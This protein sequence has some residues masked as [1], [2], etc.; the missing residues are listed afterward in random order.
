MPTEII[1]NK[2]IAE[3]KEVIK[4]LPVE[5]KLEILTL[6][7]EDL[8]ALRFKALLARFRSSARQYPLTLE[9]ITKEVESTRQE[10]YESGN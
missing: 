5:R 1:S 4:N 9:E 10:R 2:E 7:E 6:L 8:F 3:I